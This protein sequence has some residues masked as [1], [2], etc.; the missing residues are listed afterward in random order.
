MQYYV[1]RRIPAQ[2]T[3]ADAQ[4]GPQPT[5]LDLTELVQMRA[6]CPPSSTKASASDHGCIALAELLARRL[7]QRAQGC[8]GVI[9]ANGGAGSD[10][11]GRRL[12]ARACA[13]MGAERGRRPRVR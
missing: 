13:F 5:E 4:P 10:R 11:C 12:A 9:V 7:H 1:L 2:G 8:A 3:E 6:G